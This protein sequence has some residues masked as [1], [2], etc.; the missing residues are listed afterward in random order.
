MFNQKRNSMGEVERRRKK[1]AGNLLLDN[2]KVPR[3]ANASPSLTGYNSVNGAQN[4]SQSLNRPNTAAYNNPGSSPNSRPRPKTT[5]K[6]MDSGITATT[7]AATTIGQRKDSKVAK[8]LGEESI[9][10]AMKKP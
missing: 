2:R 10:R 8:S 6:G 1:E 7:T 5:T 9:R 4:H 3:S